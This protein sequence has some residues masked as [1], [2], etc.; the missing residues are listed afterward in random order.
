[1]T[2]G[3]GPELSATDEEP[4]GRGEGR[5]FGRGEV[6][7]VGDGSSDLA[8][9]IPDSRCLVSRSSRGA[10]FSCLDFNAVSARTF[11]C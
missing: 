6:D 8:G 4:G 5:T 3:C 10:L 9:R 7:A 1:M 2:F 11:S